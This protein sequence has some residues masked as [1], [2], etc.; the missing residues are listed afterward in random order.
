MRCSLVDRV[1]RDVVIGMFEVVLEP[2][3]FSVM[4]FWSR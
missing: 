2:I 1:P 4:I 3:G